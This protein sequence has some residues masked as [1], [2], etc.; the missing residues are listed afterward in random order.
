MFSRF[1][2]L[3]YVGAPCLV[4]PCADCVIPTGLLNPAVLVFLSVFCSACEI[5]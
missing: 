3:A 1:E 2:E 5:A 4:I